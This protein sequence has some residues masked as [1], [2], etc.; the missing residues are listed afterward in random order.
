[1]REIRLSGSEGGEGFNPLSLPLS[2]P[3]RTVAFRPGGPAATPAM[4]SRAARHS[5]APMSRGTT[6]LRARLRKT[7]WFLN[8]RLQDPQNLLR[9]AGGGEVFADGAAALAAV[10][11]G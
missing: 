5:P 3:R 8:G 11:G 10:F 4:S 7:L 2:V 6:P 1:M 9:H